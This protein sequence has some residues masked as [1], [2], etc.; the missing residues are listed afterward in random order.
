[1]KSNKTLIFRQMS[2]SVYVDILLPQNG[3]ANFKQ[4]P[5]DMGICHMM[6]VIHVRLTDLIASY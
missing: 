4:F 5:P 1:M 3:K 6:H 2:Y